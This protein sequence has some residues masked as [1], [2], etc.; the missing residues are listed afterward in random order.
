MS[1]Y[2]LDRS[3]RVTTDYT[4]VQGTILG[5]SPLPLNSKLIFPSVNYGHYD[6]TAYW[7]S[8]YPDPPLCL[9]DWTYSG[10]TYSD[11]TYSD[12]TYLE[13]WFDP[14][15][16]NYSVW[17]VQDASNNVLIGN[18]YREASRSNVGQYYT[19]MVVPST[20]GKYE[21]RWRYQ[22]YTNSYAKEIVMPF[23]CRS[24]GVDTDRS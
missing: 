7:S 21:I 23:L 6:P 20:T 12:G 19:S 9:K 15:W 8:P 10:G 3:T 22:K 16:I 13:R 4:F 1:G 14:Y 17:Y 2:I 18:R 24:A 11:G 5:Q